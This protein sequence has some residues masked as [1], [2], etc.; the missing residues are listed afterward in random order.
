MTE[1]AA[2]SQAVADSKTWWDRLKISIDNVRE[3]VAIGVFGKESEKEI[4][5]YKRAKQYLD[6]WAES[7]GDVS[8]AMTKTEKE[9]FEKGNFPDIASYYNERYAESI[10]LI[11]SYE[12]KVGDAK[13]KA[14]KETQEQIAAAAA[15]NMVPLSG[16]QGQRCGEEGAAKAGG[17]RKKRTDKN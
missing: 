5:S 7:T 15:K 14:Q 3:S 17:G 9:E 13:V 6:E 8:R 10:A 2:K 11:E 12:K 4:L 16:I 1:W